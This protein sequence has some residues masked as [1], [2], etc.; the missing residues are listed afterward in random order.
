L[1]DDLTS[2][3]PA[4]PNG[5]LISEQVDAPKFSRVRERKSRRHA[6]RRR[7]P[8]LVLVGL[9]ILGWVLYGVL[10]PVFDVRHKIA[11]TK[12]RIHPG[13]LEFSMSAKI[14]LRTCEYL[15]CFWFFYLGASIGSFINV[16]ANRVPRGMT[17]VSRGSHCPYCD[18]RLSLLDNMPVFGWIALRGRCR[19]CHLPIAPRYLIMELV[20]GSIFM[21]LAVVELMG[22]GMNLP[23]R[24]WRFSSGIVFTVF[25]PKWDLIGTCVVHA[26]LFAVVVMMIGSHMDSL[27]FPSLPLIFIGLIYVACATFQ[28][29][30]APIRWIEPWGPTY[31]RMESVPWE[32]LQ[33]SLLGLAAGLLLGIAYAAL[34]WLARLRPEGSMTSST[35]ESLL[36]DSPS[37]VPSN[38]SAWFSHSI[39]IFVLTGAL[40]G[41]QVVFTVWFAAS[42]ITLLCLCLSPL[43]KWAGLSKDPVLRPQVLALAI[44][45]IT[46]LMHHLFWRQLAL[47]TFLPFRPES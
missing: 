30:V 14:M 38:A 24:E 1:S 6:W 9:L 43:G 22:N 42:F 4:S 7:A 10:W 32:R 15:Y 21:V 28:P 34:L 40:L 19:T 13:D 5:E 8:L 25:Y 33:T 46:L 35:Q 39:V 17:I 45:T 20:V 27:R 26:S 16:V 23:Y 2:L 18:S 47:L 36:E 37:H 31:P 11:T 12:W 44:L 3:S 41:W 29:L